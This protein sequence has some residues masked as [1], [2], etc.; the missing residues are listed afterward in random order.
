MSLTPAGRKLIAE[1]DGTAGPGRR[2]TSWLEPAVVA[3]VTPGAA[4]DGNALCVV[5]WRG[6]DVPV[7]YPDTYIP[8]VGHTVQVLYQ[9]PSL[10]ILCRTVGTPP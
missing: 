9:P 3:S 1:L 4:A 7:A 10:V 2:P 5:T 6:I 8:S